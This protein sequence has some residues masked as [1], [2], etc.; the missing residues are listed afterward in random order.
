MTRVA[1]LSE[2]RELEDG[3]WFVSNVTTAAL[4]ADV[5]TADVY[6]MRGRWEASVTVGRSGGRDVIADAAFDAREDAIAWARR[7]VAAYD[8]SQ[9]S[10]FAEGAVR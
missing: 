5:R 2:P 6:P 8:E 7:T 1:W 9:G 4:A 10:L 3:G